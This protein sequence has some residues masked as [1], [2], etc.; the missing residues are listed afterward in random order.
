MLIPAPASRRHL[1]GAGLPSDAYA[2]DRGFLPGTFFNHAA[3]HVHHGIRHRCRNDLSY[4]SRFKC[5]DDS[6]IGSRDSLDH[7]GRHEYPAIRYRTVGDGHLQ[8]GNSHFLTHC[9]SRVRS[10]GPARRP[11][12]QSPCLTGEVNVRDGTEAERTHVPIKSLGRYAL[13]DLYRSNVRRVRD[14]APDVQ[15][16][17]GVTIANHPAGDTDTSPLAIDH[18]VRRHLSFS[19][20]RG[21]RYRLE[22]GAGFVRVRDGTVP[23]KRSVS[24]LGGLIGVVRRHVGHCPDGAGRCFI[25]DSQPSG[26]MQGIDH[27]GKF[28][29]Y[30]RLVVGI[31]GQCQ[32][33]SVHGWHKRLGGVRDLFSKPVH[34]RDHPPVFPA[35]LLVVDCL[36]TLAP[37]IVYGNVPQHLSGESPKRVFSLGDRVY[38][39]RVGRKREYPLR[40]VR[41]DIPCHPCE[42]SSGFRDSLVYALRRFARNFGHPFRKRFHLGEFAWIHGDGSRG[43]TYCKIAPGSVGDFASSRSE[44]YLPFLLSRCLCK[45]FLVVKNLYFGETTCDCTQAEEPHNSNKHQPDGVSLLRGA[46]VGFVPWLEARGLSGNS[47]DIGARRIRLRRCSSQ[48]SGKR[49]PRPFVVGIRRRHAPTDGRRVECN[50]PFQTRFM[51]RCWHRLRLVVSPKTPCSLLQSRPIALTTIESASH[52]KSLFLLPCIPP[53]NPEIRATRL[54]VRRSVASWAPRAPIV[55]SLCP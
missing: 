34:K 41:L 16:A 35:Q 18:V 44:G 53:T 54:Q 3:E 23:P 25:K 6:P 55:R 43:K 24:R 17:V 32:V 14:D 31:N 27:F 42:R 50:I 19:H 26:R 5:V 38:R 37:N 40:L 2:R 52:A 47:H 10:R 1:R 29:L 12:K 20:R 15:N 21:H 51:L 11:R 22:H 13:G 9:D 4:L 46:V 30:D 36:E 8:R 7:A 28:L 45:V 33:V 49:Q 48:L 39:H